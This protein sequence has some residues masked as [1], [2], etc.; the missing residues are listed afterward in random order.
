MRHKKR[1]RATKKTG[2][3][4]GDNFHAG[5][6]TRRRE[7][8]ELMSKYWQACWSK[9]FYGYDLNRWL[10]EHGASTF[11]PQGMHLAQHMYKTDPGQNAPGMRHGIWPF[12]SVKA[13]TFAEDP[14][15]SWRY[16]VAG[17]NFPQTGA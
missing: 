11:N 7:A 3:P 12:T 4:F 5:M 15:R 17:A 10:K 9:Q 6:E 8:D 14:I 2:T 13:I 16:R 1:D